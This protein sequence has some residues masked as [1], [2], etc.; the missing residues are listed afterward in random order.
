MTR[1][2]LIELNAVVAVATHRSFRKAAVELGVSASAL[3]H[4][5][6]SLEKRMGVRLFNRTTR[7]VT[8]SE[9]G[10]QFLSRVA[11]ALSEISAAMTGANEFRDTPVG[12]IRL[13]AA[14]GAA[15]IVLEPLVTEFLRR[16][17]DMRIDLV[18]E[19]R[20]VDIVADGFDAGIRQADIVP[21]DM[22]AVICSPPIRFVVVGAPEYFL[23]HAVPLHPDDLAQHRCIRTRLPNGAL[24]RWDFQR[25]GETLSIAPDGPLTLD[26]YNL[27]IAAA[28]NGAGLAWVNEWAVADH[29]AAGRL[30]E[31]LEPWSAAQPRLC[32]Y[33]PGHRHIPAGMRAFVALAREVYGADETLPP[34]VKKLIRY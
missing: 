7:S 8:P 32:L 20:M 10:E 13:N 34:I 3:S 2:G 14:E 24:Y 11:P 15:R 12:T 33:F 30:R 17:P 23:H 5:V 22:V 19:G 18:T 25:D 16:Y 4:S 29:M 27:M 21:Q 6:A 31:V 26:N 1:A 28:L 9:A